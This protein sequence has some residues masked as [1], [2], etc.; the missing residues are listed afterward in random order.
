MVQ[1]DQMVQVV[2]SSTW[3]GCCE[4][5]TEGGGGP[6]GTLVKA[7]LSWEGRGGG[8]VLAYLETLKSAGSC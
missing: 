3:A 1:F 5:R 4:G 6:G 8:S 7:E 2:V